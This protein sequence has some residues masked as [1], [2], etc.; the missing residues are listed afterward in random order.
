MNH[1]VE[2]TVLGYFPANQPI[3]IGGPWNGATDS[4]WA[5]LSCNDVPFCAQNS[6]KIVCRTATGLWNRIE[7]LIARLC[8][9]NVDLKKIQITT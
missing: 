5:P 6:L 2:A 8:S 1:V 7:I 3:I 9:G 4:R